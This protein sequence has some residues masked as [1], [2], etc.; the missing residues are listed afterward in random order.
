[1]TTIGLAT[2][3]RY[4]GLVADD[5]LAAARLRALGV[6]VRPIVWTDEVSSCDGCAVVVVRSCWD[7]HLVPDRFHAW[8]RSVEARGVGVWN[9]PT[10]IAWNTDKS[11]LRALRAQGVRVPETVWLDRGEPC[12][13]AVTLSARGWARAV[14]KPTISATAW[15]TFLTQ[16][17][18]AGSDQAGLDEVLADSGALVQQFVDEIETDGE[19]SLVFFDG[20]FSHAVIKRP[21]AGDFRVQ[22]EFG[23]RAE[24]RTPSAPVVEA[25]AHALSQVPGAPLYARVDGVIAR[26]AF[27]LME[28]ELI[29][30]SLFLGSDPGAVDRFVSA[31][32]RRL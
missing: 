6:N 16:P 17:A 7:Y 26:G 10:M 30:P 25:A 18:T 24:P 13:L 14:V 15:R 29:E 2:S 23:G 27:T 1:M 11:Y 12:D 9:P 28:M 31:L 22:E 5:R 20:A 19:W 4:A 3:R 8:T 21:L 32:L